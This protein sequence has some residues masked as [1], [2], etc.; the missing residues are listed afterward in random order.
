MV[1]DWNSKETADLDTAR[2][3]PRDDLLPVRLTLE[4]CAGELVD[5][6]EGKDALCIEVPDE[7]LCHLRK[8]PEHHFCLSLGARHLAVRSFPPMSKHC[9]TLFA[10][11]PEPRLL[12]SGV[13]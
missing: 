10:V 5:L 12:S 3:D 9:P 6:G 4:E 7:E 13:R 11:G 2:Q 8:A 1:W